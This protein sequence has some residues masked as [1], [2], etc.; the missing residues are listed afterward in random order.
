MRQTLLVVQTEHQT[1]Q[2]T[3]SLYRGPTNVARL[4]DHALHLTL[5]YEHLKKD[6]F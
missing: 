2:S 1:E 5:D 4:K 6:L 3:L